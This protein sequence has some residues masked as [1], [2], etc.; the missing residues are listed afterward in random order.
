MR[1]VKKARGGL[2]IRRTWAP[3]EVL[4]RALEVLR[5]EGLKAF[6][7]KGLGETFY[8]RMLFLECRLADSPAPVASRIPV[9]FH[10]LTPSDI[11]AHRRLRA[12]PDANELKRRLDEGHRAFHAQR[13]NRMVSSVWTSAGTGWIDYLKTSLSIEADEGYLYEAYTHPDFRG[14]GIGPALFNFAY[15]MLH[16]EGFRSVILAVNLENRS[17]HRAFTRSGER[18]FTKRGWVKIGP[19]R[20]D[21]SRGPGRK[22]PAGFCASDARYWDKIAESVEARP[23]Y[24]DAFLGGLKRR[25]YID[26]LDRWGTPRPDGPVL[27]TDLF[28]EANGPDAFLDGLASRQGITV[29]MDLSPRMV[30]RAR[31]REIDP[32]GTFVAA[33]VRRLPFQ[34]QSFGMIVS[35][36]TLDHF[37]QP[38]DF[39]RSLREI[40]RVLKVG[41]V[42][43]LT[44]DNRSNV[45]D[46]LL[47]LFGRVGLLPYHLGRSFTVRQ[48]IEEL[49]AEGFVVEDTTTLLQHPRL[50]GVGLTGLVNRLRWRSLQSAVHRLFLQA[51]Q[52]KDTPLGRLTGCFVAARAVM[53]PGKTVTESRALSHLDRGIRH[54][55]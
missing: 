2:L 24:L 41:G 37:F 31:E 23:H 3:R 25:A 27:K 33:D 44:L 16:G 32:E 6:W 29:G 53:P 7:F 46:P 4:E 55:L 8:R 50:L 42:L 21:F 26:L 38:T 19:W 40:A 10:R 22:A 12:S 11:D 5:E 48:M 35:P 43:I 34:Q 17:A 45:S 15:R 47:R 30:E 18:V 14:Y 20:F 52:L 54:S 51:E 36:S 1:R 28:E 49:E 9:S 39:R 13:H